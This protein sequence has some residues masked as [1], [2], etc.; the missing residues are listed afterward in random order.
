MINVYVDKN[1]NSPFGYSGIEVGKYEKEGS[2]MII[3]SLKAYFPLEERSFNLFLVRFSVVLSS[4][5][6]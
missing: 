1:D 4:K 5:I 3:D 2:L 6:G